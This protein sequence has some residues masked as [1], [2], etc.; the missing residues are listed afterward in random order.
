MKKIRKIFS[1]IFCIS[2]IIIFVN[3]APPTQASSPESID[4]AGAVAKEEL[5]SSSPLVKKIEAE[6][7]S[8][9]PVSEST[10]Y[11]VTE[12]L[13]DVQQ[14]QASYAGTQNRNIRTVVHVFDEYPVE[15]I[16]SLENSVAPQTIEPGEVAIRDYSV[17]RIQLSFSKIPNT[18]NYHVF[19]FFQ[20][21]KL[22]EPGTVIENERLMGAFG[23]ALS[24]H[25]I[26]DGT[27][28]ECYIGYTQKTVTGTIRNPKEELPVKSSS[29]DAVGS[30]FELEHCSI[31]AMQTYLTSLSGQISCIAM[32]SNLGDLYA[33]GAA[34]YT[35]VE[36]CAS[37]DGMSISLPA[38]IS[39][40]V[41][42]GTKEQEYNL[43]E[44]LHL[45]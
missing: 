14:T 1:A 9:Q 22:P 44:A 12:Y 37:I 38:G 19:S 7:G 42:F 27:S 13:D 2:A 26:I 28:V 35:H 33:S 16:S 8:L 32:Q 25:L 11:Y 17:I 6:Y 36:D 24:D 23:L 18:S 15:F 43:Q 21:L 41:S 29:N 40:S 45:S 31:G 3:I 4:P 10:C 34:L 5:F 39:L 20:W 30:Y